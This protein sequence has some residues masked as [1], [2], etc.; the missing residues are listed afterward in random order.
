MTV[1]GHGCV[2]QVRKAFAELQT[3]AREKDMTVWQYYKSGSEMMS[4]STFTEASVGMLGAVIG[5]VGVVAA[6][7][8]D[9][10]FYDSLSGMLIAGV[11]ASWGP[12]VVHRA[13]WVQGPGRNKAGGLS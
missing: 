3:Q 8:L 6:A 12:C 5:V 2:R 9:S 13:V 7:C 10:V 11:C 4:I 1:Q